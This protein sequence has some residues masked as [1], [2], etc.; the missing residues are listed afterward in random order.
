MQMGANLL[1]GATGS[2]QAVIFLTFS[3]FGIDVFSTVSQ[4]AHATFPA[5]CF[6]HYPI[7]WLQISYH[8]LSADRFL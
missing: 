8:Q 1:A 2:R 3:A 7:C 6:R 5:N 4:L